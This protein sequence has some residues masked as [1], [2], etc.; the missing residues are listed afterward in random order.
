MKYYLLLLLLLGL[1]TS[2]ASQNN[3]LQ[4]KEQAASVLKLDLQK[5]MGLQG[6]CPV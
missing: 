5:D 2:S 3:N 4:I 1:E 6:Y